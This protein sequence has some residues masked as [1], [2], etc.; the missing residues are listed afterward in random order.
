MN[1]RNIARYSSTI[2]K[3][4][5][6]ACILLAIGVCVNILYTLA[7]APRDIVEVGGTA[8]T[9]N[10]MSVDG[11]NYVDDYPAPKTGQAD[12]ISFM[13]SVNDNVSV[14]FSSQ[15]GASDIVWLD[16]S[17]KV[18]SVKYDT[19]AS[20]SSID[21]GEKMPRPSYAL[22]LSGGAARINS[23]VSGD[24]VKFNVKGQES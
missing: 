19:D 14:V 21:V 16:K 2:V 17:G 3:I 18:L 5:V 22:R 8:F 6:T 24:R 20:N 23:I 13:S 7:T 12:L 4:V 15:N 11:R 9:V 1:I 10:Y